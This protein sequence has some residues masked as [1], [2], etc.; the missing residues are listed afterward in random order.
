MALLTAYT[1]YAEVRGALGVTDKELKDD[2]LS[3][4]F[5]ALGLEYELAKVSASLAASYATIAA[6]DEAS[7]SVNQQ[8]LYRAVR[9]FAPYAL[10]VNS[11]ASGLPLL[12]VKSVTDGKAGFVRDS[13]SPYK[14]VIAEAAARY[15]LY[16][17]EVANAVSVLDGGTT[18]TGPRKHM[19][20]ISPS[21][22]PVTGK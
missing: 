21:G 3:L 9:L 15:A 13:N 12:A 11:L 20:V 17:D 14:Q 8:R 6:M 18:L 5:Y 4:E 22:D 10:I 19:D 16:R 7:R 2:V 1:S